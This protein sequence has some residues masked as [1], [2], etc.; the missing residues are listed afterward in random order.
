LIAPEGC[1][2][3]ICFAADCPGSTCFAADMRRPFI[4]SPYHPAHFFFYIAPEMLII[5]GSPKR[6]QTSS[7][8]IVMLPGLK[9]ELSCKG[10]GR[11][12]ASCTSSRL[13]NELNA[14]K[15]TAVA[16]HTDVRDWRALL[17]ILSSLPPAGHPPSSPPAIGGRERR[18]SSSHV[19]YSPGLSVTTM[20]SVGVQCEPQPDTQDHGNASDNLGRDCADDEQ[21]DNSGASTRRTSPAAMAA[22]DAEIDVLK[23]RL[24]VV[25]VYRARSKGFIPEFVVI[26]LNFFFCPTFFLHDT[27][28]LS[29]A[30]ATPRPA[31]SG[32]P[33][34]RRPP[35][36]R[37][38]DKS[39]ILRSFCPSRPRNGL[40]TS[41]FFL[42]V[43]DTL[44]G[45]LAGAVDIYERVAGNYGQLG[46]RRSWDAHCSLD[47]HLLVDLPIF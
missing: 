33:P 28:F 18:R 27:V 17:T 24:A 26:T 25:E 13:S 43:K 21:H 14:G 10:S 23:T 32:S 3:S 38:S 4:S 40:L 46:K 8:S 29:V 12:Q 44:E 45:P 34:Y 6:A 37:C 5:I 41:V 22:K 42:C 30:G 7:P 36:C 1:P 47:P 16:L 35:G 20:S 11:R 19:I 9:R 31:G 39:V 15:S 2:G